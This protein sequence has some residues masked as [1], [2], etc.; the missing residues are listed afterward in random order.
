MEGEGGLLDIRGMEGVTA[1]QA[2]G[3]ARWHHLRSCLFQLKI[4]VI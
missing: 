2:S 4:I 1:K 3:K